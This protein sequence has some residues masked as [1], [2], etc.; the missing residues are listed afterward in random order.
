MFYF[1]SKID[2]YFDGGY[3]C[4]IQWHIRRAWGDIGS[5]H[6]KGLLVDEIWNNWPGARDWNEVAFLLL[7]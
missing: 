6:A 7:A 5:A 2:R 3:G 4:Y 1:D